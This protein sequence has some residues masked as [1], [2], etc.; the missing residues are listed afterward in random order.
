MVCAP[1]RSSRGKSAEATSPSREAPLQAAAD[2][3]AQMLRQLHHGNFIQVGLF[4]FVGDLL[5]TLTA[6]VRAIDHKRIS[7][8][9]AVWQHRLIHALYRNA[10]FCVMQLS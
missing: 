8:G 7:L 10:E 6:V 4:D 5:H 2:S 9:G 1:R 3:S